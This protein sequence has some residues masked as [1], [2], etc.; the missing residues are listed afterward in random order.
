[1][2]DMNSSS[3]HIVM[4]PWLAFGHILPFTELAKRIA[5][6]GHRVTLF[7]T[8]RNTRRLIDIPRDLAGLIRVVD[9]VLPRVEHLPEDAEASIDL[10]SN[11]LR[12]YLRQ[13]YDAAFTA[14]L[15]DI[16]Q[17]PSRPD[18]VITDYAAHWAPEAA[19]RHGVPCAYLSL[20][21]AA[22]LSF[23]GPA[24]ALMGRGEHAKT[25]PEQLTEVPDFVPFPTTIA[26]RGH[27]ARQ[28][29][30][31]AAIQDAS[32]VSELYRSGKSIDASQIVGIRSSRELEPEWLQLLGE[33]YR[34]PV[35]VDDESEV[36]GVKAKELASVFGDDELNDQYVRDFLRCL[37]EYYSRHQSGPAQGSTV[38]E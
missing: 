11:D 37:S 16:L 35:M 12:P 20:Y 7:S 34:K 32:G 5:R 33:L 23:F 27:E 18:W 9:V 36:F 14:A 10:P 25:S 30:R 21:S 38:L 2:E 15:S 24:E 17:A 13:T 6:Q 31:P 26:Y 4:L 3:M 19:A 22:V 29:F 8:P 28:M 1:M